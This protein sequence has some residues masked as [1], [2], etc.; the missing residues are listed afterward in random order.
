MHGVGEKQLRD[1][2]LDFHAFDWYHSPYTMGAFAHLAPG[3]YETTATPFGPV[4]LE[5]EI[6]EKRDR[7]G[8]SRRPNIPPPP[9]PSE[10]GSAELDIE[11][12]YVP[13]NPTKDSA[14]GAPPKQADSSSSSAAG[15]G[16]STLASTA[17]TTPHVSVPATPALSPTQS[18]RILSGMEGQSRSVAGKTP[19]PPPMA[20]RFPAIAEDYLR[21][22]GRG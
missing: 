19:Q 12:T 8:R 7:A 13:M 22:P 14:V 5:F 11:S 6:G 10:D 16:N 18:A 1:D 9:A 3:Q 21:P 15:T 17:V 4:D 20:S 2:T